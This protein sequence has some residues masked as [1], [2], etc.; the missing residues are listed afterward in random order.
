MRP[1]LRTSSVAEPVPMVVF[2]AVEVKLEKSAYGNVGRPQRW[3]SNLAAP[4]IE[5]NTEVCPDDSD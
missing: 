5:G 1:Y 2:F 3:R 4:P